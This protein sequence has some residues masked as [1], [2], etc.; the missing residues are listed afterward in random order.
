MVEKRTDAAPAPPAPGAA[1]ARHLLLSLLTLLFSVGAAKAN[2]ADLHVFYGEGCPHCEEQHAFLEYLRHTY[3]GLN[4]WRY[5]VWF[6]DRHH[7]LFRDMARLHGI[8]AGSVPMVFMSGRSWVG[9]SE[10]IAAEI[11]AQVQVMLAAEAGEAR[12]GTDASLDEAIWRVRIPGLGEI[13]LSGRSLVYSTV[14]IA[15]VDGFNPCSFWILTLLLGLVVHSGSRGRVALVGAAF[16]MTTTLVYGA[17]MIGVFSVLSYVLY[18]V[19]VQWAVAGFA[20]LFGLVNVKDYF[21]Y[22]RGLSFTIPE[23]HKPGIYRGFR[24]LLDDGRSASTVLAATVVMALGIALVELPCTAGFPVLWSAMLAEQAV[25]GGE[26]AALLALY[27][28]I[29]LLYELA[30]FVLAVATLRIGRFE[31]RHGRLLKLLGGMIMLALAL[32]L[33]LKPDLMNQFAGSV[34]VFGAALLAALTI[35]ALAANRLP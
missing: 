28:S 4:V 18:L 19:W 15:F 17:F 8:S 31:E 5:E 11:E 27:L 14:L 9:H 13:E 32:T 7:A 24:R 23:R 33:I 29:Y 2:A 30:V 20:L 3:P 26:F 34:L 10:R 1:A 21:W 22:R 35:H 16:L 25:R 6:D 12:P